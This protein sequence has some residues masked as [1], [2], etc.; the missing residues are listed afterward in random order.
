MSLGI[1]LSHEYGYLS[2][3]FRFR[4]SRKTCGNAVWYAGRT[5]GRNKRIDSCLFKTRYLVGWRPVD[6][7]GELDIKASWALI[8][9]SLRL[10]AV[11]GAERTMGVPS[12]SSKTVY[13]N[14]S[15]SILATGASVAKNG[16]MSQASL[17]TPLSNFQVCPRF[18]QRTLGFN[19][20]SAT[21][22]DQI[23]DH[24]TSSPCVPLYPRRREAAALALVPIRSIMLLSQEM[25]NHLGLKVGLGRMHAGSPG[26]PPSDQ[27]PWHD[28]EASGVVGV[29]S[30]LAR[31]EED[32]NLAQNTVGERGGCWA[33]RAVA[34]NGVELC[35]GG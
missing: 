19:F 9:E 32:T 16:S 13:S 28:A 24:L 17:R 10:G 33:V 6:G 4:V 22:I 27:V 20:C 25:H 21:T 30:E 12:P 14:V 18:V 3:R 34:R 31:D 15:S 1:S 29:V 11:F 35:R 5:F 7:G 26:S 2:I 23:D 8:S